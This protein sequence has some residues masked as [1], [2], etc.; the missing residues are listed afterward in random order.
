MDSVLESEAVRAL[1]GFIASLE[2]EQQLD[3][4]DSFPASSEDPVSETEILRSWS[5]GASG[6]MRIAANIEQAVAEI[7]RSTSA[8]AASLR[9]Q[10]RKRDGFPDTRGVEDLDRLAWSIE[11]LLARVLAQLPA[12]ETH[13]T[14]F[15]AEASATLLQSAQTTTLAI[16]LLLEH[17]Y[18]LDA[19]ARWRGL[20]ELTCAASLIATSTDSEEV[21]KRYL[22]HGGFLPDDH[23]A[24]TENWAQA[25]GFAR[26]NYEW[27]R[28]EPRLDG[29]KGAIRQSDVF[30][31]SSLKSA[32]F[33]DWI[34]ESHTPVHMSSPATAAGR[35]QGGGA[36]AGWNEGTAEQVAHMVTC[37]LNE[38]V[39]HCCLLMAIQ[40]RAAESQIYLAWAYSFQDVADGSKVR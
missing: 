25:D 39:A 13:H 15:L 40:D 7:A 8:E 24:Y 1:I 34:R 3:D 16:S 4:W 32:P 14:D 38:L 36:P 26:K 29:R 5:E 9:G 22:A 11:A 27:L 35:V 19:F 20:H 31:W 2:F 10:N 23:P 33:Q 12:G 21:G 30:E 37:S 6:R 17:G 28:A 18:V